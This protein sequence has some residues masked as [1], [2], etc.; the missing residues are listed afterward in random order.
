MRVTHTIAAAVAGILL[1]QSTGFAQTQREP[2][3]QSIPRARAIEILLSNLQQGTEVR[4]ELRGDREV[5]ATF[6]EQADGDV[7]L[8]ASGHRQIIPIA[9]VVSVRRPLYRG[10]PTDGQSF[11]LGTGIGAGM[12]IVVMVAARAAMR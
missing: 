9:D 7:V 4:V 8:Q 6:V 2:A 10:T 3:I 12:L 1:I 11:A 5:V